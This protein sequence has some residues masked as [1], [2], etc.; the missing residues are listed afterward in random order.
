MTSL[1][2]ALR[3][4]NPPA[5]KNA[6]T[7]NVLDGDA[8]DLSP[9]PTIPASVDYKQLAMNNKAAS[10]RALLYDHPDG[11]NYD[12]LCK[13]TG[14]ARD[15]IYAHM[16]GLVHEGDAKAYELPARGRFFKFTGDPRRVGPRHLADAPTK[17]APSNAAARS[18]GAQDTGLPDAGRSTRA[19][20]ATSPGRPADDAAT[21]LKTAAP[22]RSA[23]LPLP[24][25]SDTNSVSAAAH[26]LAVEMV[27]V[28]ANNL[29]VEVR[30]L[31]RE[32]GGLDDDDSLTRALANFE[33]ADR[34]YVQTKGE[35][36]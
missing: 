15:S 12:E 23:S 32:V 19:D 17:A 26:A 2:D 36:T 8:M 3:P 4:A 21:Q 13:Y 10:L 1:L 24:G 33:R 35:R 28:A 27:T 11:L 9:T 5:A 14:I 7:V 31:L 29:A 16:A 30:E 20:A 18:E 22:Q 25:R 34:L 6:R